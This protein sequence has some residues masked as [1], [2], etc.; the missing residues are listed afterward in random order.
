MQP[1]ISADQMREIDRLTT[2]DFQITSL[3]LMQAAAEAC[4]QAIA[5]HFAGQLPGK[6]AL[7]LCGRGNNG[8]DGAALALKLVGAG[9]HVEVVLFGQIKDASGDARTNFDLVNQRAGRE[10]TAT[11]HPT[12]FTFA[13]CDGAVSW[14]ALSKPCDTYDL[15]VDALFGTGLR[16]PLEGVFRQVALDLVKARTNRELL[17]VVKPLIVS[18]D[19]PSGLNADSG[20]PIGDAVTADITVTFTAPKLGN[21]L[22]PASHL[23]GKLVV[24]DIGSPPTLVEATKS[25][26]LVTEER[27]ARRWLISTRYAPGSFKNT[28]G[29]ALVIAGSRGYTGAAVLCG[30]AAMRSGAGLVTIATPT[31]AQ[32]AVAATAMPEIMTIALAETDR[33]AVS[34]AAIDHVMQLATKAAVVAIGPGLTAEDERTRQFVFSVVTERTFPVVLDADA[35][36]C[37]ARYS[38][39]GWPAEL[40]GSEKAPLVLTPHAGEMLRLLGTTDRSALDDRVTVAR[41]F[42]TK[43]NLILVLKGSRSLVAAPDGRVFINPTGNEGLGTA[44][45]GDTLTGIIAGF[46]AQDR[47][48][49]KNDSNAL[50]ATITALY[51]GGLA[52]DIAAREIGMRTMVASDIRE[53]I[54]AA[55]CSLDPKGEK[56]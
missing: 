7:V 22:P 34:D 39:K 14:E 41:D 45:A 54:S 51:I 56:P 9:V 32:S 18:V 16:R 46:I 26:L 12:S 49:L 13:E 3:S 25:Q 21:V 43:H 10:T 38:D 35:L 42:A 8:G 17:S 20:M 40:R 30:D 15:I 53:H 44:G 4:F 2:R 52:G 31:S 23:N 5:H 27:D 29:H 36:N 33:G 19:L 11:N 6:K 48:T 24:A 55:I 28:H 47:A 1:V 37:L 50:L